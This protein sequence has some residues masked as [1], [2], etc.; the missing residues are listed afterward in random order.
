[1]TLRIS[2]VQHVIPTKTGMTLRISEVQHVIPTKA[3]MTLRN[4][5]AD[6][7]SAARHSGES[8]NPECSACTY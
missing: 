1:M 6:F 5:A 2:E 4:E 3:G 8:R 7:R